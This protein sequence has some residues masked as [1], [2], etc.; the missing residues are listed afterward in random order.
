MRGMNNM[1]RSAKIA[2]TRVLRNPSHRRDTT[3]Q[4]NIRIHAFRSFVRIIARYTLAPWL[5]ISDAPQTET[6]HSQ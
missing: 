4:I 5:T 2:P 3:R 1:T 6:L